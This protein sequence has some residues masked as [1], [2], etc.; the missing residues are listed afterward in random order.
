MT[1]GTIGAD[2]QALGSGCVY[3]P[4]VKTIADQL[5]DDGLSLARLHAGHGQ[6]SLARRPRRCGA[7]GD[8]RPR[9][10]PIGDGERPVRNPPQPVRLLPFGD[11]RA[12][13]LPPHVVAL[14]RLGGDLRKPAAHRNYT[15]ITPDLCG[16]GH[17]DD[18]ADP[19]QQ[20][21]YQGIDEFL[22]KWVPKI[23]RSPAYR[24]NGL[25]IV[26]FDESESGADSCCFMP[27]G[28]NAP[29]QGIYGPGGGRVGT[30]L[31]SPYI[32]AGTL[33]DALQP[34][35]LLRTIE[36]I[37]GLGHLGYAARDEVESFGSDVFRETPGAKISSATARRAASKSVPGIP[38]M[39]GEVAPASR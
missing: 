30:V 18:C 9:P 3:P 14:D 23:M 38:P 17:D 1:P 32:K 7:S 28:P 4:Q 6:R 8:R 19:R 29:L 33:N 5:E 37:F 36:D 39:Q 34:L 21:G 35:R 26:T 20:G 2:G 27:T 22:R 11:R 10:D 16:D 24:K 13:A 12:Q 31:L 25:L 15:F